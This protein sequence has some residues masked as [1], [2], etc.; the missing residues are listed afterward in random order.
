M[1]HPTLGELRPHS[2]QYLSRLAAKTIA[3]GDL[4]FVIAEE[5]PGIS[6]GYGCADRLETVI[7]M[8]CDVAVDLCGI[9]E[10]LREV[11]R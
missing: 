9:V 8:L 10:G 7:E 2:P 5:P 4:L 1:N 6:P 3:A 11:G